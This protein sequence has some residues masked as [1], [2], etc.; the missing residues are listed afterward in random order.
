MKNYLIIFAVAFGLFSCNEAIDIEQPGRLGAAQAF[1]TVD[2]LEAGLL[3]A[4]DEFD[5][6]PEIQ[7]NAVFTD[8]VAIGFDNGGQGIGN[9]EYGFILNPGSAASQALWVNYNDG[10]NATT[11]VIESAALIEVDPADQARFNQIVGETLALRA[12][13]HFQLLSYLSTD[14]TDDSALATILVNFIPTIDQ[15]LPRN[16]NAEIYASINDDLTRALS[17]LPSGS[18]DATRV[19]SDFV[20]ALQARMAAYRGQYAQADALAADLLTR[21]PIA[22]RA[23]YEAMYLDTDNTEVIFKLERAFGDNYDGQGTTGSGFAGGWAGANFA[24]VNA[25]LAGSP[26]FEMG[27]AVFNELDPADIR[28][29][30]NVAPTSVIDPDY[31]TNQDPALDILVIQKY[32]GSEGRDLM[33]DL[34]V[35]RAAEMLFIRAEAAADAGNINGA[36]NSTA[37]YLKQL[38]DA[39]FG[40]DQPLPTFGSQQEAFGAILDERRIEL[41]YEGHRWKDLK[42]LGARA[43]RGV[44]RD[45]IDCAINGACSLPVTDF[46]FT[47]PIPLVELNAN[48]NIQQNPGY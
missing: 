33:N 44:E 28:Y 30:V 43:N 4:Y 15:A 1:Q 18:T 32:P 42:R 47:M 5:T 11:R 26:Y 29:D 8:E 41:V 36:A 17:L 3:G 16:T 31:T 10:L 23:E 21:Y 37:A 2:D 7:F 6:T 27:R 25:T 24:F 13:A 9:G 19:S 35:F 38:R 34:K 45:A 14:Y 20:L 46:R 39:R 12:F 22:S 40:T 48:N